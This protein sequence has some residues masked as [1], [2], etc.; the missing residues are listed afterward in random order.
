MYKIDKTRIALV[1]GDSL[2]LNIDIK[3]GEDFYEPQTEDT[4]KFFLRNAE[5]K[6]NKTEYVEREPLL[7]KIIPNETLILK[8]DQADTFDL[9]FGRYNY[10]IKL[11]TEDDLVDTFIC[12]IFDIVPDAEP[13]MV[14][15]VFTPNG[16]KVTGS[17]SIFADGGES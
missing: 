6:N 9:S 15:G 1:R 11:I 7:E 16:N 12:D 4:I 17:L 2:I 13:L 14:N 5:L 3:V 8:L 10:G